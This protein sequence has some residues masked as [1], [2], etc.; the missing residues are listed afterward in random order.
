MLKL[1]GFLEGKN[2]TLDAS[3]Y[4]S[5]PPCLLLWLSSSSSFVHP[6]PLSSSAPAVLPCPAGGGGEQMVATW[7]EAWRPQR[8][9]AQPYGTTRPVSWASM[10]GMGPSPCLPRASRPSDPSPGR[11]QP[12]GPLRLR[13]VRTPPEVPRV[14]IAV[15]AERMF[16]GVLCPPALFPRELGALLKEFVIG[17]QP[18]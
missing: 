15:Q 13:V 12:P 4:S 6:L 1:G 2:P 9:P 18:S 8:D 11:E 7:T 17:P 14:H 16:L 3:M 10:L 5:S